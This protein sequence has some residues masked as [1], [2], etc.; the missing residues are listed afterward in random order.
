LGT[1]APLMVEEV[2]QRTGAMDLR[3][4]GGPSV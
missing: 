1:L 3:V 4:R 2:L